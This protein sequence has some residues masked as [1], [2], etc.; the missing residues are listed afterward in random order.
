MNRLLDRS[1]ANKSSDW[2][3]KSVLRD[4]EFALHNAI[5]QTWP[6]AT[7]RRRMQR[8][9]L[10]PEY[11]VENSPIRKAFK[12]IIALPFVPEDLIPTE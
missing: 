7:V 6:S 3:D 10:V 12:F 9:D 2:D 5:T 11:E 8:E 4:Y 1:R